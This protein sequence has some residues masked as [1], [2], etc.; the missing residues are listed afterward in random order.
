MEK[1]EKIFKAGGKERGSKR[2]S[3]IRAKAGDQNK[4]GEG[5]PSKSGRQF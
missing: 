1:V 2:S 5:D 4:P 3:K